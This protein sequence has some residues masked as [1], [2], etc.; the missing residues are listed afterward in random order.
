MTTKLHKKTILHK[1]ALVAFLSLLSKFLGII[2]DVIQVQYMGVGALSDAFNI[3]FKIPQLLRKIFADGALSA[4]FIPTMVKVMG[5]DSEEQ[6]SRLVT[7]IALFFGLLI[8]LLC[9]LVSFFPEAV[10]D[11][12]APGFESK[13][14]EFA[15]AVALIRI[16][17]YFVFFIFVSALLA[18][19]LQ[20]K[21]HFAIPSFGPA[22]L[23]IFYIAGLLICL[24]Y[25]LNIDTFAYF[26]LLG[27]LA[28]AVLCLIVYFKLHFTILWPNRTTYHYLY[29]VFTKFLPCTLSV[30]VVEINLFI[31]NRFASSLPVGSVTLLTLSSRFMTIVLGAFAVAFSSILL[32]HFSRISRDA[33]RRL[34]FYLLE[35]TQ[36][37]LWITLPAALLMSFFSYDIFYTIFYRITHNLTLEQVEEASSLL[38][39]FLPGLFF[40]SLNKVVLTIYYSLHETKISTLIT[41]LGTLTNVLLNRLLMPSYGALGIAVATSLAA[42]VQAICFVIVLRKKF[43]FTLYYKRFFK[44]LITYC[45]Q[46]IICSLLFYLLYKL[47]VAFVKLY[48]PQWED[49]L[50]HHIGLWLWV[51]PLSLIFAV[52]LYYMRNKYGMKL[53]FLD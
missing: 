36:L 45:V 46:I 42:V 15:T 8:G 4:A 34:S 22:L 18:G 12:C 47:C 32:S 17:I 1:T 43:N 23:N 6:A 16:L 10:I 29:E 25:G 11:L 35:S 38:I 39:A 28:Q 20:A 52:I 41:C 40:F 7:S 31:D 44:F 3:A 33:P 53:Y 50:L 27:G 9:L 19:A 21:M 5:Q 51:G 26:I 30:G 13:A 24:A 2:R 37:I 49:F 14:V 48:M